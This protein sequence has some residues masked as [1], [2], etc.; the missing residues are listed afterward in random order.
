MVNKLRIAVLRGGPG[1]ESQISMK[2]GFSILNNLSSDKYVVYDVIIS[3]DGSWIVGG[4]VVKPEKF[5]INLDMVIN[6]LHGEYGEDGRVQKMLDDFG[7]PY[8]GSNSISSMFGM[9]KGFSKEIYKNSGIKTPYSAL[10]KSNNINEKSVRELFRTFPLPCIIKPVR[11][12]SSIGVSL[13]RDFKELMSSLEDCSKHSDSI[14]IEEFISGKEV[15][16]G[17]I[18]NFR[19]KDVYSLL[20]IE[21]IL[22]EESSFFDYDSKYNGQTQKI[23]PGRF[24]QAESDE[25]QRLAIEAHKAL[26]LRHYSRSDFIVHPKR[27]IYILETN[28]L[29]GMTEESLFPKSLE[30]VGSNLEEFLEH[31]IN[32][33][34]NK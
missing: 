34:K 19:D 8:T 27:G 18:D 32:L 23:L 9:N 1:R 10:L 11:G 12:G 31:L 13:A 3:R 6:A 4:L 25:I 5:V 21:I 33:A 17:V 29:P 24:S 15:T 22:S 20:P 7:V 26:G 14:L 16:C 2:T 28:S 30:A